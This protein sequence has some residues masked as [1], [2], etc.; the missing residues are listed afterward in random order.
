M[1]NLV[2]PIIM[3]IGSIVI[4]HDLTLARRFPQMRSRWTSLNALAGVLFGLAEINLTGTIHTQVIAVVSLLALLCHIMFAEVTLQTTQTRLFKFGWF[5]LGAL[6]AAPCIFLLAYNSIST[7]TALA[8]W[9][10]LLF[11]ISLVVI[12]PL[13]NPRLSELSPQILYS[14]P[15]MLVGSWVIDFT[16]SASANYSFTGLLLLVGLVGRTLYVIDD[17][18]MAYDELEALKLNLGRQNQELDIALQKSKAAEVARAQFVASMSH[19]I[20]T[21][22]NGVLGLTTLL[23]DTPLNDEQKDYVRALQSSG[24]SLRT[25]INDVLDFEQIDAGKVRIEQIPFAVCDLLVESLVTVAAP[26]H[27]SGQTLSAS[28]SPNLPVQVI[29]DTRY[30]SQV[31]NNLLGNAVKFAPGGKITLGADFEWTS[32]EKGVLKITV[33][34]T[35]K[36]IPSGLLNTLFEPFQQG[37]HGDTREFGGS[38]L[39][40]AIARNLVINMNGRLDVTS[41]VGIGST[42]YVEVPVRTVDGRRLGDAENLHGRKILMV[43]NHGILTDAYA[44]ILRAWGAEVVITSNIPGTF[45][46]PNSSEKGFDTLIMGG[47]GSSTLDRALDKRTRASN[48]L[49]LRMPPL[50]SPRSTRKLKNTT[51]LPFPAHPEDLRIALGNATP[52]PAESFVRSSYVGKNQAYSVMVVEDNP[53]NHMVVRRLLENL[54]CVVT[55]AENGLEALEIVESKPWDLILMD[56]Q[57]P[58]M[59]GY[60]ATKQLRKHLGHTLPIIG[61]TANAMPESRQRALASGMNDY[62]TKPI[63]PARLKSVVMNSLTSEITGTF[64]VDERILSSALSG[65]K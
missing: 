38:G 44:E 13:I 62:L 57:M 48:V 1:E 25:L 61:L 17:Q 27:S 56:C 52:R 58:K 39:G 50:G 64:E 22:L 63:D 36:G 11:S 28:L 37:D 3:C 12:Q 46:A 23:E 29:G 30:L 8:I 18:V 19:E 34:D 7:N 26:S 35:G 21:P 6:G 9:G 14:A 55:V 5:C 59:D 41:E 51:W 16:S 2:A 32:T 33:E 4:I 20:R 24:R 45:D 47:R 10:T 15:G 53:V 65:S 43:D 42:F 60:E 40:L 31:L 49:L 54:G